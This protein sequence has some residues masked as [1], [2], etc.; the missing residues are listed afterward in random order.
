MLNC[1]RFSNSVTFLLLH[2]H[3]DFT[4][5]FTLW[6]EQR[7]EFAAVEAMESDL[8]IAYR[9]QLQEALEASLSLHPS[10]SSA[11]IEQPISDDEGAL[12]VTSL[13]SEELTRLESEIKDYE[14]SR[15]EIQTIMEDISRRFHDE[16]V[17][18]EIST[19]SEVD[20]QEWGDNF[21]KPFGEG[22]SSSS[23]G[24]AEEDLVRVYLKGLV[25]EENVRGESV[26]L[27]GL[28]VAICDLSDNLLFEVSKSAVANGIS[29][30]VA[31]M[32]ALVEALNLALALNFKRVVYYSDYYPLFQYVSLYERDCG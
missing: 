22:S 5:N 2:S 28:G 3:M 15:R 17:A 32:K 14:Q 23:S 1:E 18:R 25:S 24:R 7:R 20:W 30:V 27:S 19:I 10:S 11:V 12:N 13:Q 29:K 4:E 21:E 9:L 16:K 26:V 31:E 6:S 8:D